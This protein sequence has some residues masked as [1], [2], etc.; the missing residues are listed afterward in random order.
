MGREVGM[1][2]R[3]EIGRGGNEEV[4]SRKKLGKVD[5]EPVRQQRRGG[6]AGGSGRTGVVTLLL[7]PA[8]RA[9][10]PVS[11]STTGRQLADKDSLTL[12]LQTPCRLNVS[13]A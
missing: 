2:F 5:P 12:R 4:G 6:W 10:T 9:D 3:E 1:G 7:Q 8:G 11:P 13:L